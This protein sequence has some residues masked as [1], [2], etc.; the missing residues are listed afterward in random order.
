M[1]TWPH[2][3]PCPRVV[4]ADGFSMSVQVGPSY[5]CR[6]SPRGRWVTVEIALHSQPEPRLDEY[7]IHAGVEGVPPVYRNVP[8]ATLAR[9]VDSHGGILEDSYQELRKRE[10]L[11]L[12][13]P[14]RA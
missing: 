9:I 6:R 3:T 5:M 4:C 1:R 2:K 8:V 11:P 10:V 7:N 13:F 12:C 14:S